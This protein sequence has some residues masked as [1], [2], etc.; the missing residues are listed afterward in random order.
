MIIADQ[1]P[2]LVAKKIWDE[3]FEIAK[4]EQF[5]NLDNFLYDLKDI[6][7]YIHD[8]I[9]FYWFW[10]K[11]GQTRLEMNRTHYDQGIDCVEVRINKI[12]LGW[13]ATLE[14]LK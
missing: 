10:H 4:A 13:E 5:E 6:P 9:T 1:D 3:L 8:D 14:V 11:D 2:K 7:R 12:P